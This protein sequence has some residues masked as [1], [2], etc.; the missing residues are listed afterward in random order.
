MTEQL[1]QFVNKSGHCFE[2]YQKIGVCESEKNYHGTVGAMLRASHDGKHD[3]SV[4]D[5][6]CF[7][8]ELQEAGFEWNKDFYMRKVIK[9]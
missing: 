6:M 5:A 2:D 3:F 8:D 7:R 1:Y 4:G 9:E